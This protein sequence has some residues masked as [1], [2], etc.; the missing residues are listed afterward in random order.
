MSTK[1]NV[2]LSD[3]EIE[4]ALNQMSILIV[5]SCK[6]SPSNG[7]RHA[8]DSIEVST[9][10]QGEKNDFMENNSIKCTYKHE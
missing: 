1:G 7:V 2:E 6:S 5:A 8:L 4:K 10:A 9:R 3:S